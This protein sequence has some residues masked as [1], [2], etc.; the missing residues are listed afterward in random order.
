MYVIW[1]K[2]CSGTTAGHGILPQS[3]FCL[4]IPSSR[5]VLVHLCVKAQ[6]TYAC[7]A[8]HVLVGARYLN[9]MTGHSM[10]T[11]GFS[12]IMAVICW[13]C[14]LPRTFD[15]LS[16]LATLSAF[17]TFISVLLAAI[18]AGIE[19]KPAHYN[20]DP[21]FKDPITG[22]GGGEPLVLVIP[23]AGTTFVA[24]LNAFLNISYTFIGQITLPSFIA[25]MKKP[26]DFPKALWAVTIAEIIVFSCVGAVVYAYTGTQYNTAPAFYSLSND[27]YKKVS[28]SFMIPTLIFLGVLYASVS[29]RFLFFRI[30]EGTRHK[31]N[32][33]MI[34]WLSWGGILAVT[35]VF[36]FIIAEVIPFF[37]DLLSLMSSLFDSFFGFIFWAV[38][39]FRMRKVDHGAGYYKDRGLR[40]WIGFSVNVVIL[41]TGFFFLT[42]GKI[43][44]SRSIAGRHTYNNRNLRFSRKYHPGL[45]QWFIW[46]CI[47]VRVEWLRYYIQ[48]GIAAICSEI[49]I[50]K[51]RTIS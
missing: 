47:H 34:G 31:G 15:T 39:Y 6:L 12:A 25:E 29:A 17:F 21:N 26:E 41:L 51:A 35:W 44:C 40:G 37:S 50:G 5:Y 14:S 42:A 18:F 4:T 22:T 36:A 38:A 16:K 19:G 28:F 1:A 27:L 43:Y 8:L 20:P 10:C 7:E 46:R 45:R 11:V 33:T 23:A 9:T 49:D 30:F 48:G 3:C 32:H 24:G 2:C 13:V